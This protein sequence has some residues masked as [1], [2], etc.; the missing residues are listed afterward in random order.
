M[1]WRPKVAIGA[2]LIMMASVYMMGVTGRRVTLAQTA[3]RSFAR[4]RAPRCFPSSQG[5]GRM[6][7]VRATSPAFSKLK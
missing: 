4:A 5:R 3:G 1:L 2:A 7:S 6:V